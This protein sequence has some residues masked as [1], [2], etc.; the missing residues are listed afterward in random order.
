MWQ[1]LLDILSPL[2]GILN[3][4]GV[5]P[6]LNFSYDADAMRRFMLRIAEGLI[7]GVLV[8]VGVTNLVRPAVN[9]QIETLGKVI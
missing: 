9:R 2:Y 3:K 5:L 6:D 1:T 7:G 4:T 8:I